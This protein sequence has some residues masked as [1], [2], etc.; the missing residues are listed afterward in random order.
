M[1]LATLQ[2]RLWL[3]FVAP[4]RRDDRGASVVEYAMLL[5]FIFAVLVLAVNILGT[6]SSE[7]LNNAGQEGFVRGN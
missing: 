1:A 3:S 2:L 6:T 4:R 5:A 7:G